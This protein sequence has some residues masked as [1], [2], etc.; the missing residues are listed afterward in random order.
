MN[1]A[2]ENDMA[3]FDLLPVLRLSANEILNVMLKM[4]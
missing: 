1:I 3:L 2:A 4:P